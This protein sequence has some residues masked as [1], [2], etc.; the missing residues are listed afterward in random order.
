MIVSPLMSDRPGHYPGL[1]RRCE[2]RHEV[3]G[4]ALV[5]IIDT[6]DQDQVGM[7][8]HAE[9][10]NVSTHGMNLCAQ[11]LKELMDGGLFELWIGVDGYPAKFYLKCEAQWVSWE[12]NNEFHMGVEILDR[13]DTDVEEWRRIQA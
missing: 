5:Q 11:Q 3:H 4:R 1:G 2:S 13:F 7:S 9:V 8:F 12:E 6:E 10:F